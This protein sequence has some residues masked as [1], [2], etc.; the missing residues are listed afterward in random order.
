MQ[1]SHIFTPA[2]NTQDAVAPP[3]I[4]KE[5]HAFSY[6]L[7]SMDRAKAAK[8]KKPQLVTDFNTDD[9]L[10]AEK[11]KRNLK[12]KTWKA[13]DAYM[14]WQHI[15]DYCRTKGLESPSTQRHIENTM[16]KTNFASVSFN[17]TDGVVT[18][19]NIEI[20]GVTL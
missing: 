2:N 7:S 9:F 16:R 5:L 8:A 17:R 14:K 15:K 20:D 19:L 1:Y 6:V 10:E 13:M 12:A 4:K 3:S 11:A 18:A